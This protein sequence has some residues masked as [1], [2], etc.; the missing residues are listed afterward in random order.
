MTTHVEIIESNDIS[1]YYLFTSVLVIFFGER[2]FQLWGLEVYS[3]MCNVE[4]SQTFI[5]SNQGCFS[6][7]KN[8]FELIGIIWLG[9]IIIM[10]CE[11]KSVCKLSWIETTEYICTYIFGVFLHLFFY[12]KRRLSTN[13][14]SRIKHIYGSLF[15][16][17]MQPSLL[18]Y[19]HNMYLNPWS[20][21][22]ALKSKTLW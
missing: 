11:C 18:T 12:R 22:L 20:I 10:Y 16:T 8:Q 2:Q 17:A 13:N 9:V 7:G 6:S 5:P 1:L 3:L 4:K 14:S 21:S 15:T 19:F